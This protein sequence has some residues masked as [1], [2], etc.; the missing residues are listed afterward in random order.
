MIFTMNDQIF[1]LEAPDLLT[2]VVPI[3]LLL[4]IIRMITAFVTMGSQLLQIR[5]R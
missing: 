5:S 2:Y 1:T 3:I 4:I